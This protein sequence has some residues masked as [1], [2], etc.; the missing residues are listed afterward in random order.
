[1]NSAKSTESGN[2]RLCQSVNHPSLVVHPREIL[3]FLYH[4]DIEATNGP[5]QQA[6]RPAVRNRKV[7]AG[8]R[9]WSGAGAQEVLGSLF[10]TCGNNA[11]EFL[12]TLSR[13][14]CRPMTA[15]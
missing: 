15:A 11:I 4:R 7:F 2:K 9:A 5:G 13:I 8:Y 3:A 12:D 6:M 10:A 1:M 14:I